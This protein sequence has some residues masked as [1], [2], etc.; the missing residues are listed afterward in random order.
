MKTKN[1]FLYTS[2][3]TFGILLGSFVLG[4]VLAK[5]ETNAGIA[6]ADIQYPIA[7]LGNC[8]SKDACKT[9]CD[10]PANTTACLAFAEK[11]NL[12]TENEI[13]SAKK[14]LNSSEKGPGGCTTKDSCQSYCDNISNINE[15][16]AYAEKTGILSPQELEEA[17]LVQ[18]AIAKGVKPPACKNKKEC[19]V[20]C[21][22][23]ENMN[24]CISFGEA[25]GFLKGKDLEDAKKMQ[26]AIARGAIPPRC[27]G[28]EACDTYCSQPD[29]IEKCMTFAK[30]AGFMSPEEEK[31]SEQV[32]NAIRKGV[33]PPPCRGKEECD[34]YCGEASHIEECIA[35]SV[36]AGFMSEKDAEMARK[37][38]GKGPGGCKGKEECDAFCQNPDNEQTCI[39][40]GKE[41]GMISPEQLKQMEEGNNKFTESLNNAPP[42]VKQCLI[43]TFGDLSKVSPSRENGNKMGECYKKFAESQ[44]G[45]GGMPPPGSQPGQPGQMMPPQGQENQPNQNPGG[46]F[47]QQPG[48][49]FN[50]NLPPNGT[51]PP[52]NSAFQV[53]AGEMM[54]PL[55]PGTQQ[56][57]MPTQPGPGSSTPPP[58]PQ[59]SMLLFMKM[60][61]NVLFSF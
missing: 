57:M 9:F 15:C 43:E 12:M 31:N 4:V 47:Q 52:P 16:V 3:A 59:S 14:F 21:E 24:A 8:Q 19:D 22:S 6:S 37:T 17:K 58:P 1:T 42:E 39:N 10:K 61:A 25:A 13:D 20:F 34:A 33:K 56:P 49:P 27:R 55:S 38:G 51:M 5:A 40:F 35:F 44:T 36:A 46:N 48:M 23:P 30:A 50:P 54:Q 26:A 29:N 45:E 53:P 7:D 11:N 28:K 2:I 41:N 18:S 60:M 32:L